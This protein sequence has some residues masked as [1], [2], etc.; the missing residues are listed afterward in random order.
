MRIL[1]VIRES[2]PLN[3]WFTASIERVLAEESQGSPQSGQIIQQA[4]L[5]EAA[6]LTEIDLVLVALDFPDQFTGVEI[7]QALSSNPLTRWLCVTGPWSEGDGRNRTFWPF[8]VRVPWHR[9]PER[10][11]QE[12]AIKE[13]RLTALP[14]TASRNECFLF[15]QQTLESV[16]TTLPGNRLSIGLLIDDPAL[17]LYYQQWLSGLGYNV[18]RYSLRKVELKTGGPESSIVAS[19]SIWIMDLD[20]WTTERLRK[21]PNIRLQIGSESSLIGL[22]NEI[23]LEQFTSMNQHGIDSVFPKLMGETEIL[24]TIRSVHPVNH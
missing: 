2:S 13:D 20:P 5:P 24:R 17:Q 18:D 4:F 19:H 1:I 14:L 8:A 7:E 10:F 16:E 3:Q 6:E 12:I 23:N 15:E 9:F 11:R 22:T 21:I